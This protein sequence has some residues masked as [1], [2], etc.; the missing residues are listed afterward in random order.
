MATN[1]VLP[2]RPLATYGRSHSVEDEETVPDS[3]D[4][5]SPGQSR[6][7][8]DDGGIPT[9]PPIKAAQSPPPRPP[10]AVYR[11]RKRAPSPPSLSYSSMAPAEE[12]I[13]D[14]EDNSRNVGTSDDDGDG[15]DS[16]K[17]SPSNTRQSVS[18]GLSD[19]KE[20][21]RDI[22]DQYDADECMQRQHEVSRTMP[23]PK[24]A[25]PEDPF[26]SP[27]TT[28]ASSQHASSR[29]RADESLSSPSRLVS[30]STNT[31]P[32]F[33]FGTPRTP[34]PS[35]PT[36]DG[37]PSP[38]S[39]TRTKGKGKARA[40]PKA[41]GAVIDDQLASPPNAIRQKRRSE[42]PKTSKVRFHFVF[43]VCSG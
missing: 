24:E 39:K 21:L 29:L 10:R 4:S 30:S 41:H 5:I 26:G 18:S 16:R 25:Y 13:P 43:I 6:T 33:L 1:D 40:H 12:V 36:S 20:K 27:L 9:S 32:H 11:S 34:S 8:A 28:E 22:D 23:D 2:R 7:H 38:M 19:W 42:K 35:P 3:E 14:S 31:T 37:K 15:D 17:K